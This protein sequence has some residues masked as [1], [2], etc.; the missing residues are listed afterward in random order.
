MTSENQAKISHRIRTRGLKKKK[1]SSWP[2]GEEEV[3]Q[4]GGREGF[5]N[6]RALHK[7]NMEQV[8][9]ITQDRILE[10][11]ILLRKGQVMANF[12]STLLKCILEKRQDW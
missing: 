11:V 2:H 4:K 1:K 5:K 8:Q 10:K 6:D 9:C 12:K 7:G 3:I